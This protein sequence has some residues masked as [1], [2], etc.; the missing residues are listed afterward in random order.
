MRTLLKVI[1][2]LLAA[3]IVAGGFWLV[4]NNTSL[5]NTGP[6]EHRGGPGFNR[7]AVQEGFTGQTP[8]G[9]QGHGPGDGDRHEPSIGRSLA[10]VAGTLVKL[11]VVVVLVLSIQKAAQWITTKRQPRHSS[12]A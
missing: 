1:A 10:E 11:T 2:I 7:P 4:V 3:A 6:G 5:A 12:L 9:F 8:E